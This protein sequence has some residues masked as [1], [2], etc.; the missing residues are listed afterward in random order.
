MI[1]S[2]PKSA[3]EGNPMD[4]NAIGQLIRDRVTVLGMQVFGA[5]VLYIVGRWLIALVVNMVQ[6]ALVRQKTEATILTFNPFGPVLAGDRFA[7]TI[8]TGRCTSTPIWRYVRCLAIQRFLDRLI[9]SLWQRH[10]K[11]RLVKDFKMLTYV[12]AQGTA[13]SI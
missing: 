4:W 6:R 9:P 10:G 2:T 5:L 8:I 12:N 3:K 1:D 7:I 11:P 13:G